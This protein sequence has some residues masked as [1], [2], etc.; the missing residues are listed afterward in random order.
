SVVKSSDVSSAI[1]SYIDSTIDYMNNKATEK[2]TSIYD[3]TAI[4]TALNNDYARWA[5][6]NNKTIDD[7]AKKNIDYTLNHIKESIDSKLDVMMFTYLND[8]GISD[9]IHNHYNII[10]LARIISIS[11]SAVLILLLLLINKR[12]VNNGLYWI[13]CSSLIS[14]II[15]CIPTIYL[16]ATN[17]FDGL[18]LKNDS[19]YKSLTELLY[20]FVDRL[21]ICGII[22]VVVGVALFVADYFMCKNSQSRNSRPVYMD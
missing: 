2:P 15:F 18:I 6:E 4:E 21:L 16:K 22:M 12:H 9:F 14:G 19:I 8:Y 1:N 3:Y 13:G 20:N 7:I 5:K 10:K 11:L 17:Y